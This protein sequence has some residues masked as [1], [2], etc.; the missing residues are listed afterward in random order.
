MF[1]TG[2][3]K[4][5]AGFMALGSGFTIIGML[6]AFGTLPPVT[7]KKDKFGDIECT[8]VTLVDSETGLITGKLETGKDGGEL[9]LWQ[10]MDAHWDKP[11]YVENRDGIM[12]TAS[13]Q[14]GMLKIFGHRE[15]G[16]PYSYVVLAR[17]NLQINNRD[18]GRAII[19]VVSHGGSIE[20]QGAKGD[21]RIFESP[22]DR[23]ETRFAKIRLSAY[24]ERGLVSV[25]RFDDWETL[26]GVHLS[27]NE[28]GGMLD[29]LG[30][31]KDK[32]RVTVEINEYGNGAVSTW[33][34]NGYRQ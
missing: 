15:K 8:S 18:G 12:L 24:G 14:G 29:V 13:R 9:Y 1:R 17:N 32:S 11:E 33:D 2:N 4:E 3:W 34:K 31:A 22:G 28:N 19:D 20:I 16:V 21:L 25:D 26:G 7:A 23:H 10:S 30:K 6:I 27:V 5:R